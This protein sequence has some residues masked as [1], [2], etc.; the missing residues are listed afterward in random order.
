MKIAYALAMSFFE[1]IIPSMFH[2]RLLLL[3]GVMVCAMLVL[4]LRLIRVT[5]DE[6]DMHLA[7][8]NGV[9]SS[10]TVVD[11][12]RG[13]IYDGKGRLLAADIP[14]ADIAVDFSVITGRWAYEEAE[15]VAEGDQ[16]GVWGKMSTTERE[17][18][19][20][21]YRKPFDD[22]LEELWRSMA[23]YSGVERDEIEE[24]KSS[25]IRYVHHVKAA[26]N[27][28]RMQD[29]KKATRVLEETIAHTILPAVSDTVANHFLKI[30]GQLPGVKVIASKTRRYEREVTVGLDRSRLPSMIRGDGVESFTIKNVGAHLLGKMRPVWAEDVSTEG[31]GKGTPGRPFIVDEEH[32][33]LGGYR[34]SDTKG[35]GGVEAA[36]EGL[37]RGVRGLVM[38]RRD[39]GEEKSRIDLERGGDATLTVDW[40]LQARVRAVMEPSFGLM[41]VQRFHTRFEEPGPV[42]SQMDA[43]GSPLR[44]AAVVM[45]V[46]SGEILAMVSTPLVSDDGYDESG[47]DPSHDPDNPL[48]NK[49]LGA[50]YPPGSTIKPMVY[51]IAVEANEISPDRTF[52]CQGA[53][54]ADS[55]N[56]LRCWGWR[57]DQGL[58]LRHNEIDAVEAIKVSCN[59]FFY[60][61]GRKL[62]GHK[63]VSGFTG[64]GFGEKIGLGFGNGEVSGILPRLVGVQKLGVAEAMMM[65]IGQSRIA[66]PPIQVAGAHVALARGGEYISP[67]LIR[68]WGD[69]EVYDLELRSA[70]VNN[71]LNGMKKAAAPG[72]LVLKTEDGRDEAIFD[73]PG[74]EFY[75]KTGTAQNAPL[76]EKEY[77]VD[78]EGERKLVKKGEL[79]YRNNTHSWVVCHVKPEGEA[80]AK[81]VVVVLVEYGGS[82]SRVAGPVANQIVWALKDEGYF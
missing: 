38:H 45:D 8:I 60:N 53:M 66:V 77:Q 37:L 42:T 44:G 12:V 73:V 7:R 76:W 50:I 57:P 79:P 47:K 65:A 82:G 17:D 34:P 9:L 69:P 33:D 35:Q 5:Y 23:R 52:D 2:R 64:W 6:G 63:L 26:V 20:D 43:V 30:E 3:L 81:Y 27:A 80:R 40:F 31:D 46:E 71:A 70:V 25:I 51:A 1:Q 29:G 59:I 74:V 72:Q 48:M 78:E 10:S 75:A 67:S 13:T 14:S 56:S 16:E 58:Y 22:E 39:T 24:R 4:S 41:Q 49:P 32:R 28:R 21:E 54:F 68:D 62:G 18:L 55:P 15:R 19:I 36:A 11:T 61:C